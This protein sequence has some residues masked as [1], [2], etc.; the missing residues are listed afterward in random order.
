MGSLEPTAAIIG[1]N[2]TCDR[3]TS[4]EA[5]VTTDEEAY[6]IE[7]S[8][9]REPSEPETDRRQRQ[10]R[11]EIGRRTL[12]KRRTPIAGVAPQPSRARLDRREPGE[13]RRLPDRR[14][15]SGAARELS[16]IDFSELDEAGSKNT[17]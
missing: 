13:R 3:D 11:M 1:R 12:E 14:I 5:T 15:G 2:E 7:V 6:S 4:S 17:I 10:R 8:F 9:L 16:Q